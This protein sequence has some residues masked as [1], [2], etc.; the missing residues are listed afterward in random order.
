MKVAQAT[1]CCMVID[2]ATLLIGIAFSSAS[3]FLALLVGWLNSRSESYLVLNAAGMGV[4]VAALVVLSIRS[5]EY[6][7]AAQIIPFAL[8]LVGLG[9]VYGGARRLR[10]RRAA[11]W[12]AVAVVLVSIVPMSIV[13]VMGLS[14]VGTIILNIAAAILMAL[15]AYEHWRG[16]DSLRIALLAIAVLYTLTAMSFLACALVLLTDHTWVVTAPPDN[17]AEDFN[18]IMALVGLT[19]IGAFTLT[20]HHARVAARHHAEANT[21]QLTGLHNRRALFERFGET[22]PAKNT[23]VLMLDLDHFKQINDRHGHAEGDR[24]LQVFSEVMRHNLRLDDMAAR[25]GGEEFCAVLPDV[26]QD[27]AKAIAER[28]RE[29]YADRNFEVNDSGLFATVSVGIAMASGSENLQDL[30]N[31]ADAALYQ[32]KNGGRN[33]V[34]LA[35][36]RLVA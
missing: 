28:I 15:C 21:D 27:A 33:Q 23:A 30:L 16:K 13:F 34:R 1:G 31:L 6:D 17:W 26:E 18:S 12:P 7:L 19:G 11:L 8:I 29:A 36:L 2:N 25:I 32:A 20:L 3:L 14:G 9:L 24:M 4:V 5:G 10:N 35:P 22:P